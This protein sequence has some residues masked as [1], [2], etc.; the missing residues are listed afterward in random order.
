MVHDLAAGITP[1]DARE[2]EDRAGTLRWVRS[3]APLFRTARPATPDP[4]LC[5]YFALL[6]DARGTVLVA[7]HVKSGLWLLPGG[8]VDDGEDP[9]DT[10]VREAREELGVD[11]RFHPAFGAAPL[12]LTV[13]RTRG[14]GSHTDVSFWFVLAGA[15][16]MPLVVDEREAARVRWFD[17]ADRARWDTRPADPRMDAFRG[18][19]A[20]RVHL[21]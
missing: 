14:A 9:R 2:A 13:T 4:H 11:A 10:V 5:V 15:E 19:L 21:S 12:L 6:D 20:S 7:D 8:H 17:V 18:K 1:F 16:D 3:G